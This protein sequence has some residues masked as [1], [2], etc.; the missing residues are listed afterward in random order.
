MLGMHVLRLGHIKSG[1]KVQ[2]I[3]GLKDFSE[4]MAYER[5]VSTWGAYH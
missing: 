4:L 2:R 1:R 3:R 5:R